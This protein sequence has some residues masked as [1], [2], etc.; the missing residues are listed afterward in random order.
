MARRENLSIRELGARCAG[1][2]GK[3]SIHGGTTT[4]AISQKGQE[5]L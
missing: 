1:A 3:N 2:R 5:H 4:A